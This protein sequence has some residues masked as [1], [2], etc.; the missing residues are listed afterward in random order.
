M[1]DF[2]T[3]SG[4]LQDVFTGLVAGESEERAR[5][6]NERVAGLQTALQL[7]SAGVDATAFGDDLFSRGNEAFAKGGFTTASRAG[8]EA[9]ER[10]QKQQAFKNQL[11]GMKLAI[12]LKKIEADTGLKLAT[13]HNT[14]SIAQGNNLAT[15]LAAKINADGRVATAEAG[16]ISGPSFTQLDDTARAISEYARN[17]VDAN[18][19]P[20]F[21][22]GTHYSV[23]NKGVIKWKSDAYAQ[24][25]ARLARKLYD[26]V[27]RP[28]LTN[29]NFFSRLQNSGRELSPR[30]T[31][32]TGIFGLGRSMHVDTQPTVRE[33]MVQ[34]AM[35]LRAETDPTR[36]RELAA[37][38]IDKLVAL[39]YDRAQITDALDRLLQG[40]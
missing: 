24:A 31:T 14:S 26:D 12:D 25:H 11:E 5:L 40:Q 35:A 2:G 23:D 13:L 9:Y 16:R 33:K 38:N 21:K 27:T 19:K 8:L 6:R 28:G 22:Q 36:R 4:R 15:M 1:P 18:D 32:D 3:I 7:G 17:M 37:T 20:L 10:G 30:A 34:L 39:G 29:E